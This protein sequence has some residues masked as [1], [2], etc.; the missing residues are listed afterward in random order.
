MTVNPFET[1]ASVY[2]Q[3]Y[4]TF[5][6]TFECEVQALRALLPP[7]G[8]WV[9]VGVGTGRFAEQLDIRLG[10]EPTVGMAALA[11]SRGIDVVQGVAEALPLETASQDAI[12]F[13]TT[14]CFVQHLQKAMA[15]AYRVLRPNGH[16]LVG[17]LPLDSELGCAIQDRAKD[18]PFFKT[19]N[20]RTKR[21]VLNALQSAGLVLQDSSQTLFG[22][23]ASFESRVPTHDSGHDRG[24]FVA[25]R[26]V[27]PR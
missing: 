2:D 3:W 19:A 8:Q 18:D 13:I 21:D 6:Q 4:D 26:A 12:F 7:P 23:P 25:F 16:C 14:L 24:S 11:R 20:L 17:L 22:D 9:E 10:V 27:K 1:N 15:E 5:P